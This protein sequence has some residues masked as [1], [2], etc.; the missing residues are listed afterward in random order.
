MRKLPPRLL[1]SLWF[2]KKQTSISFLS[3]C[4]CMKVTHWRSNSSPNNWKL[5]CLHPSVENHFLS[6]K[7]SLFNSV[8]NKWI[9]FCGR[10]IS[11]MVLIAFLNH[12]ICSVTF[13]SFF[14]FLTMCCA[15]LIYLAK[16]VLA[17][18]MQAE[19]WKKKSVHFSL[20]YCWM[21]WSVLSWTIT[22]NMKINSD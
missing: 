21:T 3:S 12:V 20:F 8:V 22:I 11:L 18:V 2:K 9:T 4:P 1:I 16:V 6:W 17:N 5:K 19:T 7:I 10:L 13:Q 15:V 14:F